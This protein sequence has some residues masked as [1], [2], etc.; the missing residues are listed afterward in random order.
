MTVPNPKATREPRKV[1]TFDNVFGGE[2]SQAELYN[3]TARVIVDAVLEGYN[4]MCINKP[5]TVAI[6]DQCIFMCRNSVRLWTDW[7]W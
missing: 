5:V 2:S 7:Y 3:E 1:F 4:G 6:S